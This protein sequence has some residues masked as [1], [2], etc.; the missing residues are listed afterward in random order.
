[1]W[2]IFPSGL[3]IGFTETFTSVSEGVGQFQ[4]HL[5]LTVPLPEVELPANL[6]VFIEIQTHAGLYVVYKIE[7]WFWKIQA[8]QAHS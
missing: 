4:L 3:V 6:F 2:L 7:S 5:N 8:I 1:M